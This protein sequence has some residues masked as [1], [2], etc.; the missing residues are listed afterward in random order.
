MHSDHQTI[1]I[2]GTSTGFGRSATE[3]LARAGHHVY[4]T[5]RGVEGK[6]QAAAEELRSLA[7]DESL[8]IT[9]LELDVTSA[10][11]IATVAEQVESSGLD[12]LVHNAGIFGMAP[13]EAYTPDQFRFML[14][15]NVVGVHALTRAM[16]PVM[17]RQKSGLVVT[18]SSAVGR[19]TMPGAAMYTA[20]KFAVEAL[21]EGYRYDTAEHGID[22]VLIEPG[23]YGTDIFGKNVAPESAD[24]VQHYPEFMATLTSVG[25]GLGEAI[26]AEGAND[27]AEIGRTIL[28]LINQEAGS[29][30]LRVPV[31]QDVVGIVGAL[32]RQTAEFQRGFLEAFGFESCISLA[33]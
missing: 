15:T 24:V 31:G 17:R 33:E 7:S 18:I 8:D 9:V 30:P 21:M 16:L 4:A 11:H 28:D 1:L 10:E 26:E 25:E 2:T 6:N 13:T 20:T 22:F 14:E 32:N 12:V 3:T 27:P 23:A 19:L 29:R 5:M